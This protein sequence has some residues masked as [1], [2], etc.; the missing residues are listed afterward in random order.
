MALSS[1]TSEIP[2]PYELTAVVLWEV[3]QQSPELLEGYGS[4]PGCAL[5]PLPSHVGNSYRFSSDPSPTP[6]R[7]AGCE[8]RRAGAGRGRS[9]GVAAGARRQPAHRATE[10]DHHAGGGAG[11]GLGRNDRPR[12]APGRRSPRGEG[13]GSHGTWRRLGLE[14]H[15]RRDGGEGAGRGV[16]SSLFNPFDETPGTQQNPV[17]GAPQ[18]CNDHR[19]PFRVSCLKNRD[20]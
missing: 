8:P 11:G 4:T 15:E 9:P 16:R 5:L 6:A 18:T 19:P 14:A 10:P 3:W 2:S 20:S 12:S 17:K 1:R 13:G 7:R